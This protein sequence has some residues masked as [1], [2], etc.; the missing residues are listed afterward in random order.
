MESLLLNH[1]SAN[2]DLKLNLISNNLILISGSPKKVKFTK[3]TWN[4]LASIS[5]LIH[6]VDP[7]VSHRK[8]TLP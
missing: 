7:S 6:P 5:E 1:R 2:Q 4:Y 8:V 3:F